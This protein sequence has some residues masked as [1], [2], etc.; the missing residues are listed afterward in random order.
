[1]IIHVFLDCWDEVCFGDVL[2]RLK[3][4]F[5]LDYREI[6]FYRSKMK[7]VYHVTSWWFWLCTTFVNLVWPYAMQILLQNTQKNI[8]VILFDRL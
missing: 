5:L 8:L 3:R 7:M 2:Q 4:T 6:G 1:M